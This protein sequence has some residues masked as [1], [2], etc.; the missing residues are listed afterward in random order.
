M[1]IC[2]L[3]F[4]FTHHDNTIFLNMYSGNIVGGFN[5]YHDDT[6]VLLLLVFI[7]TP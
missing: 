5:T 1:V 7:S 2:S 3:F 6:N 4:F